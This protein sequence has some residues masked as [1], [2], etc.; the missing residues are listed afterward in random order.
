MARGKTRYVLRHGILAWGFPGY[1]LLAATP[2][3]TDLIEPMAGYY[4]MQLLMCMTGG[5]VL[6]LIMWHVSEMQC[7]NH[8][9]PKAKER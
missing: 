8:A 3:F 9:E 6:A 2:A 7:L 1:L 4:T 5:T